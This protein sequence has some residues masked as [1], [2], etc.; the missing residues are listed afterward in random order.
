MGSHAVTNYESASTLNQ[1]SAH[2]C[3]GD[4]GG[5]IKVTFRRPFRVFVDPVSCSYH[6]SERDVL[7]NDAFFSGGNW[8]K[9]LIRVFS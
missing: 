7:V 8:L 5:G 9:G 6:G 2:Q 3:R 4:A 1:R